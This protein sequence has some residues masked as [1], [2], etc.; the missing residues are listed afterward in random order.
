[1]LCLEFSFSC[2]IGA[3]FL[4]LF[5]HNYTFTTSSVCIWVSMQL[6]FRFE[7]EV[8][9]PDFGICLLR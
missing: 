7:V 9:G 2:I 1:M 8:I 4:V 5:I 3:F 6:S